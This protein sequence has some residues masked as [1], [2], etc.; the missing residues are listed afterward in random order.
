[1]LTFALE[2][3]QMNRFAAFAFIVKRHNYTVVFETVY[4]M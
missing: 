2:N 1:M 4:D 3:A